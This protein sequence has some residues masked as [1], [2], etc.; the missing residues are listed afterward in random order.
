MRKLFEKSLH[1]VNTGIV[2]VSSDHVVVLLV[3][4]IKRQRNGRNDFPK[5]KGHACLI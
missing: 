4:C 2:I 3:N 1:V 5:A